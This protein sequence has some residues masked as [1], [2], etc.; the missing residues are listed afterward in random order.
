MQQACSRLNEL[1]RRLAVSAS[2]SQLTDDSQVEPSPAELAAR[3]VQAIAELGPAIVAFSGGVDS[4]V[5]AAACH[6]ADSQRAANDE[7]RSLAVTADSPSLSR[8]QLAIAIQTAAQIGIAHR[9]IETT[10]LERDEYR[11]NDPT[12]CFYC[13][14]T[15]YRALD[16]LRAHYRD[17]VILSG[18]NH[19]DLGDYRPGIQ[20]GHEAGVRAP[21]AELGIG[22]AQVR[23]LARYWSLSVADHPAQPCLSSRIAYGVAV[24]P[25]RLQM[26]EQAEA[27]LQQ[28]GYSPLRVRLLEGDVASIEVGQEQLAALTATLET[29]VVIQTLKSIGFQSVTIDPKGFRSGSL[30]QLAGLVRPA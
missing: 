3:L 24:T 29:E 5:V 9:V 1:K 27:C 8:A 4:A 30:V 28:R 7:V 10:E 22:K 18:T 12:R 13:K 11:R 21:L 15:L 14:Q 17:Q 25:Q 2:A 19:D 26:I 23:R 16:S 6:R 20:A